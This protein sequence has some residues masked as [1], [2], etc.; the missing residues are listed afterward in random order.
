MACRILVPKPETEPSAVK[1]QSPNHWTIG[2]SPFF[3]SIPNSRT[4][5]ELRGIKI[6]TCTISTSTDLSFWHLCGCKLVICITLSH[7]SPRG[8]KEKGLGKISIYRALTGY[9]V[10]ECLNLVATATMQERYYYFHFFQRRK[11]KNYLRSSRHRSRY[12]NTGLWLQIWG[13]FHH[14]YYFTDPWKK[15]SPTVELALE[16]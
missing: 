12:L 14:S 16:T 10:L 5:G 1:V 8:W 9:H 2:N 3:L 4:N 13:F 6:Q 15:Q 11:D 7:N